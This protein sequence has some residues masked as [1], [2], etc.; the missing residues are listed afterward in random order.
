MRLTSVLRTDVR[1]MAI[2]IKMIQPEKIV[3]TIAA[4]LAKQTGPAVTQYELACLVYQSLPDK[5]LA[6]SF[7]KKQFEEVLGL[8]QQFHLI[9]PIEPFSETHGYQLFGH[10]RRTVIELACSLDPFAYVSHLSSMEHYGLTDRFSQLVYLTRP[11]SSEWAALAKAKMNRDLGQQAENFLKLGYPKLIRPTFKKLS[12]ITVHL[13]ERSNQGAFRTTAH[14]SLRVA[15]M[16][17]V[18]LDMLREPSLCG[19]IQ[20]VVD[21]YTHHAKKY[22]SLIADELNT[23]G[24]P[25]DKV[26]AGYLLS[27]VC[28]LDHPA[29]ADWEKF[30]QRGGSRK[31]DPEGEFEPHYSKRW[32]LSINLPSLF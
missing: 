11:K 13:L 2:N 9:R 19:G 12:G 22:L 6:T 4:Q 30:A 32:Q 24:A 26:R 8:L 5:K 28:K 20:H 25:I 16:G 1:R 3:T 31:L 29:F 23:H 27:E 17:R 7:A 18:F 15:T 10:E 14:S 21:I